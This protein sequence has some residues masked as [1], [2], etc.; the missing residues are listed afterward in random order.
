[1]RISV[2]LCTYSRCESLTAALHSV[3]ASQIPPA[4]PWEVLVIDNN[5]RDRTRDVALD[6][7]RR[8]PE[9]FRYLFE[10]QQG[11]SHALNLGVREASG[12]V[13][14]FMDDDVVVDPSWLRNLTA[15]LESDSWAGA[16]GRVIPLWNAD[17]P[18]WLP[19]TGEILA[20]L[21]SFNCGEQAG[22]LR[23]PPF[24]TNM[25]FRK[26]M[27]ERYGRF[28]TDLGPRPDSEI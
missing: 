22:T 14:A 18:S 1:M 27:F 3:A 7:S 16:G 10:S 11:K 19:S 9:R 23:E 12:D 4:I 17:R 6:F 28:R 8:Y 13:I 24:G 26:E 21:V 2:I 20:P 5:S 15:T 25:A